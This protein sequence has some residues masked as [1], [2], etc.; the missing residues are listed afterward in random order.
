MIGAAGSSGGTRDDN[1]FALYGI[2]PNLSDEG[3]SYPKKAWPPSTGITVPV[4]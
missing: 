3:P 2:A 1:Y 4:T